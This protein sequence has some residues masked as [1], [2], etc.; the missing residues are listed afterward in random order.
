M[1]KILN[2]E[3]D[4]FYVC[5]AHFEEKFIRI[6]KL[7]ITID[8]YP[9]LFLGNID[10]NSSETCQCCFKSFINESDE[11]H[12]I[13]ENL[14]SIF[15]EVM[16]CELQPGVICTECHENVVDFMNFR[17]TVR[18]K[19]EVREKRLKEKASTSSNL[20]ISNVISQNPKQFKTESDGEGNQID[21]LEFEPEKIS[22]FN[23]N[24][25]SISNSSV[26][27]FIEHPNQ[28]KN[29]DNKEIQKPEI[30]RPT[31]RTSSRIIKVKTEKPYENLTKIKEEPKDEE[32]LNF[33]LQSSSFLEEV[34][35]EPSDDNDLLSLMTTQ[36]NT[37]KRSLVFDS[38]EN[39]NDL[40]IKRFNQGSSSYSSSLPS[41]IK[42]EPEILNFKSLK[43]QYCPDRFSTRDEILVHIQGNHNFKCSL[44][45]HYFNMK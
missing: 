15:K 11:V 43:C 5:D 29:P 1:E 28:I 27:N 31:I 8:A 37:N 44:V 3:E 39:E 32:I 45:L 18:K 40:R 6:R 13:S 34:K 38:S 12:Q 42:I 4:K 20:E 21:I 41:K 36:I 2:I 24:F 26:I 23:D 19:Q 22:N 9:S 30:K 35:M 25:Q 14:Q 7:G 17:T 16:D 10:P 33:N